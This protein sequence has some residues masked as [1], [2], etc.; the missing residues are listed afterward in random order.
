M[1]G[2]SNGIRSSALLRTAAFP[3]ELWLQAASPSLF[4]LIQRTWEVESSYHMNGREA[5]AQIGFELIPHPEISKGDRAMT[6]RIR[7]LLYQHH[8]VQSHLLEEVA[9]LAERFVPQSSNL[10]KALAVTRAS[11]TLLLELEEQLSTAVARE[12]TRLLELPWVLAQSTPMMVRAMRQINS[13][14]YSDI[15][16]RVTSGESWKTK[17]MRQRS[18]YL[19]RL[20]DRGTIKP[21][22]RGWFAHVGLVRIDETVSGTPNF[23][24][25][26][27][28]ATQWL[29]NL[30]IGRRLVVETGLEHAAPETLLGLTPLHWRDGPW[31]EAWI[32]KVSSSIDVDV[33][34]VKLRRTPLLEAICQALQF[35]ARPLSEVET[36]VAMDASAPKRAVLRAFLTH[37]A[38]IGMIEVSPPL[39]PHFRTLGGCAYSRIDGGLTRSFTYPLPAPVGAKELT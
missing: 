11:L 10:R 28:I 7:R 34:E 33:T 2:D 12:E 4:Q 5:A 36:T 37:L 21:T 27:E 22:P 30:Y 1:K 14:L 13:D 38:N 24:V 23:V 29:E 25:T 26:Q 35:G 6:L 17:R 32:I 31:L 39:R 19:W 8:V 3:S 20:I 9:E 15:E 18:G 16:R